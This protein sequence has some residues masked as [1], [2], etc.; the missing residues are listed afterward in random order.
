[1]AL[2]GEMRFGIGTYFTEVQMVEV[3]KKGAD[4]AKR[5]LVFT[6]QN[7]MEISTSSDC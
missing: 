7:H 1:M 2:R 6:G 5:I 3:N 4:E